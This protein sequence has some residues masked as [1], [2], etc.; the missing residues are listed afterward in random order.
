V[1][2]QAW[3]YWHLGPGPG[4]DYLQTDQAHTYADTIGR[5]AARNLITVA[6]ARAGIKFPRPESPK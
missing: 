5:N 3:T 1:P 2:G 4:P 6:H